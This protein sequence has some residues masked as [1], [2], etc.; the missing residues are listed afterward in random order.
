MCWHFDVMGIFFLH[1]EI[2]E[3]IWDLNMA[4]VPCITGCGKEPS[5]TSGP[6]VPLKR[7][8]QER[9]VQT[10]SCYFCG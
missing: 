8:L 2:W 7:T 10:E 9:V 1:S 3:K 5:T 6:I 4:L